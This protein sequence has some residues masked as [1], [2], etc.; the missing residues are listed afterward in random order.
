VQERYDVTGPDARQ[1]ADLEYDLAHEPTSGGPA[2][3]GAP[4]AA[5][6]QEQRPSIYVPTE[7]KDYDGDYGYDMAH[8]VPGR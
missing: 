5:A 7:T 1:G 2:T 4:H 6:G 3:S 8:D